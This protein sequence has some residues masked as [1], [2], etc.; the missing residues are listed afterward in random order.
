MN[1]QSK[2]FQ[3]PNIYWRAIMYSGQRDPSFSRKNVS[4]KIDEPR[5]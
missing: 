4:E 2:T 5:I 3:R 1:T